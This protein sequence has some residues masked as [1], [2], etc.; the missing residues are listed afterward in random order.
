PSLSRAFDVV[1]TDP[2]RS[3]GPCLAFLD[4]SERCLAATRRARIL[5]ADHPD[6]NFEL[7]RVIE[8]LP[9]LGLRLDERHPLLHRYPLAPV[10]VRDLGDKARAL[11]V[12]A[13]LLEGL[14]RHVSGY[15]D[16]L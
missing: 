15:T 4:V 10:W 1:L 8:A 2:I 5:W 9:A 16:L 3:Y 11:G 14:A 13:Q 6:W 12:P 7:D